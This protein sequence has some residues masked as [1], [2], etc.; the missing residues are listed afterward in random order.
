MYL[1]K[2]YC[3][4]SVQTILSLPLSETLCPHPENAESKSK[5]TKR[6]DNN[7]FIFYSLSA[8]FANTVQNGFFVVYNKAVML[9]NVRSDFIKIFTFDMKKPSAKGTFEMIMLFAGGIFSDKLI[10]GADAFFD[11]KATDNSLLSKF[12][13]LT[14]DGGFSDRNSV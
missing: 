8:I 7:L 3:G 11:K 2:S 1:V 9:K 14:V 12:F 10:A 6:S 5:T 13:E 4:K